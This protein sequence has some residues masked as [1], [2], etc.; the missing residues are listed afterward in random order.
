MLRRLTTTQQMKNKTSQRGSYLIFT[1]LAMRKLFQPVQ[2]DFQTSQR[3]GYFENAM[4]DTLGKAQGEIC[5]GG[6]L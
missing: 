3:S 1:V 6:P 2:S 4:L 5:K